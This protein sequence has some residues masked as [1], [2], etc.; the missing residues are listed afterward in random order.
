[1]PWAATCLSM[2][3]HGTP[4]LILR[5]YSRPG[6]HLCEQL[7]HELV[8]LVRGRASVEVLNID[9]R[10]D[11]RARYGNRIPVVELDGRTLS[12]FRLDRH[13]IEDALQSPPR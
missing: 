7:L 9:L 13:A 12:E 6:C 3:H 1:M 8:P 11:L 2:A 4:S 5:V 10:D